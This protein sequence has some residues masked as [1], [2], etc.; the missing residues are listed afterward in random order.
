MGRRGRKRRLGV[1]DEYWQLIL[2]GVGT[3]EACKLVGVGRKTGYRWRA[4]RG[5]LPPLRRVEHQ[6]SDRY[7]S[8]LERQRIATLRR[9]GLSIREIARQLFRAPSTI[10]R[11]LRR[12][13]S[14]HDVG[15]YDGDLAH[16]RARERVER[17][18]G[19]RLATVPGLR[20]AVQSKLELEWSPE[21]I[22]AW[23]RA[24]Y[25][26]RPRWHVCHETIYQALYSGAK[27]GLSR[28][29]TKKLR[30]GRPLR[31]RRRR[32][33][34]RTP[35]FIAPALLIDHRPAEAAE[36]SRV[37]DW[38][39]DLITGRAGQSAIGTLVCRRGR[40]IKLVHLPGR[41]TA[42]DLVIG[43]RETLAELPESV[44]LTLTWDQGSEMAGHDQV[45]DLFAEGV[46]FAHAGKPW[47]RPTNENSN[48]LL[49][50][51]FPKGSDLRAYTVDDLRRV[52]ERLNTRPRKTLGWITPTQVLS[53]SLASS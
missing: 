27:G 17:P 24:E 2:A 30:T 41:R 8:L 40:Y 34:E 37:G 20:E 47:Q 7:L 28:Q 3:V 16:S 12:N 4:E 13:T 15:G 46:F 1:E 48:G 35:R 42:E 50:Q 23:L 9:H 32:A 18:R 10:S 38:E 14:L 21:Q 49:R 31:K 26:G 51:Y 22:A 6:R 39:G 33:Q 36:R 29:L 52:E 43:L 19:G 5:G 11:E 53:A 45:A 44:R 25:P